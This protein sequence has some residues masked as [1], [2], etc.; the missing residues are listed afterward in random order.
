MCDYDLSLP[1]IE[2]AEF[3]TTLKESLEQYEALNSL[4]AKTKIPKEQLC[5]G[6]V[7]FRTSKC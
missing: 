3:L 2:M 5:L 4:E 7:T 1:T 6:K